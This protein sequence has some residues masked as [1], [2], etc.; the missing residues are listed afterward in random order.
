LNTHW[1]DIVALAKE[2]KVVLA[3]GSPRRKTLLSEIGIVFET[4]TPHVAEIRNMGE[5]PF[6][7]ATRLAKEKA[8]AVAAKL[9]AD[10]TAIGCDTIVILGDEVLE[11]PADAKSAEEMLAQLSG[12]RH[13][14]C[15][16][17]ALGERDGW[18][19]CGYDTTEVFFKPF[20][21]GQIREYVATGEPMDKAGSYGIQGMGAFL[22]DRIDGNLDTVV[23]LPCDLLN[24]LARQRLSGR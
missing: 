4:I 17:I 19:I 9:S 6:A 7:Y 14:V 11:K 8:L 20:T 15:S 16:A 10:S 24:K 23:G 2:R 13:I 5:E 3:S 1:P 21:H 18:S 12:N 22:V